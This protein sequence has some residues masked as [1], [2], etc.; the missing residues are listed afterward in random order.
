MIDR[1]SAINSFLVAT[2]PAASTRADTAECRCRPNRQGPRFSR[3]SSISLAE[4]PP[5]PR[6][7]LIT[8]AAMKSGSLRGI[9]PSPNTATDCGTFISMICCLPALTGSVFATGTRSALSGNPPNTSSSNLPSVAASISP[10]ATT[11]R[12]LLANVRLWNAARSSRV[13]LLTVSLVPFDGRRIGVTGKRQ[14]I[15][16]AAR[17]L[18]RVLVGI[19]QIGQQAAGGYDRP[20]QHRSAAFAPRVSTAQRLCRD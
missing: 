16:F 9:A 8:N 6:M 1:L 20:R 4:K 18:I 14:R 17:D 7:W 13:I 15:P 11:F 5:P 3:T 10:T 2:L 12:L 19:R